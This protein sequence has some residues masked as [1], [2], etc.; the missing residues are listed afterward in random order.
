HTQHSERPPHPRSTLFPYTPLFRS[1]R[2]K[3]SNR[4][5]DPKIFGGKK[6][7]VVGGGDSA[8]ETAVALVLAG[9][10]VVLSYRKDELTRAKSENQDR[11]STRLNS[12]HVSTSYAVLRL[13]Q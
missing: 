10:H 4:L 9:A 6:A 5:H 11:Q 2:D 7:L 13:K 1:E 8:L 12:S 3:V